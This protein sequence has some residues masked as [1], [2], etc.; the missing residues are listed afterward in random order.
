MLYEMF[1]FFLEVVKLMII[2]VVFC[3]R[4]F[5]IDMRVREDDNFILNYDG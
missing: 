4:F 2:D 1:G 3:S 5:L